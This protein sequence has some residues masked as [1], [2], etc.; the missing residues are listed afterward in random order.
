VTGRKR[1]REIMEER[2]L[3]HLKATIQRDRNEQEAGGA[4]MRGTIFVITGGK[5][6]IYYSERF[7]AVPARPSIRGRL[8]AR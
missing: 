7:Q 4:V 3:S 1:T 5:Q 6:K 8:E 2:E